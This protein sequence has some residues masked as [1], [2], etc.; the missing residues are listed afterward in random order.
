MIFT[1]ELNTENDPADINA[2]VESICN[3]YFGT[4]HDMMEIDVQVG[5]H[6]MRAE[7]ELVNNVWKCTNIKM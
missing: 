2:E 4:K 1:F 6:T 5:D 3:A 7:C